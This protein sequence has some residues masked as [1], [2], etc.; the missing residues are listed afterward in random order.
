MI[1]IDR[2]VTFLLPFD[3]YGLKFSHRLLDSL[4]G[5]S[6]FLLRAMDQ[7]LSLADL[8]EVTG[9]GQSV[10]LDQLA[11]LQDHRYLEIVEVDGDP[12]PRLTQRGATMVKVESLLRDFELTVWLDAFTLR[13]H[14]VHL[15]LFVE[16][17]VAEE[18]DAPGGMVVRV[19]R[20]RR[21]RS[22][23]FHLFDEANRLR[24]LLDKGAL[25]LLLEYYWGD[26]CTL[27]VSESDHW[28]CELH[29][30]TDATEQVHLP[31]CFAPGELVLS[32]HTHSENGKASTL[33]FVSLPVLELSHVFKPVADFPWPVSVPPAVTHNMELVSSTTLPR[34]AR[35]MA[36]DGDAGCYSVMCASLGAEVPSGIPQPVVPPGVSCEV[37]VR[38]LQISFTMDEEQ[39]SQHLQ[40]CLDAL[41]MSYNLLSAEEAQPA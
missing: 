4:G 10:L 36:A 5:V 7:R 19:P 13:R 14:A 30:Q 18:G 31:A 3:C 8:M 38:Q 35:L 12:V 9:L 22:G 25:R 34:S 37:S 16:P 32:P 26:D 40:A 15:A 1:R 33:P 17:P 29:A 41:V 39:L 27:I 20:R 6:R 24:V 2:P 11:F 23:R 21:S 28:E